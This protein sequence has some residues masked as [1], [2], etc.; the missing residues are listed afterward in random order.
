MGCRFWI[1]WSYSSSGQS[2]RRDTGSDSNCSTKSSFTSS[3]IKQESTCKCKDT[4]LCWFAWWQ[5]RICLGTQTGLLTGNPSRP[6]LPGKPLSPLAPGCPG[7]PFARDRGKIQHIVD[8]TLSK[9][10]KHFYLFKI[11]KCKDLYTKWMTSEAAR[12]SNNKNAQDGL[13]R[14]TSEPQMHTSNTDAEW[15]QTPA[16]TPRGHLNQAGSPL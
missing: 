12:D 10:S 5:L 9:S 1:Q 15:L 13:R 11:Q 7:K 16:R 14:G 4:C 2:V 6:S 3:Q 8:E